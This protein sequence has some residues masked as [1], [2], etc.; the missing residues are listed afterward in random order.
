MFLQNF[1]I[2]LS[3]LAGTLFLGLVGCQDDSRE[4]PDNQIVALGGVNWP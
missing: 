3:L 1:R 4:L 2:P